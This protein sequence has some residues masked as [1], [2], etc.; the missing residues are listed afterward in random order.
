V[1][2]G[3]RISCER[4]LGC[5][6]CVIVLDTDILDFSNLWMPIHANL[7]EVSRR[8]SLMNITKQSLVKSKINQEVTVG[9]L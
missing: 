1:L 3:D 6:C 2:E 9:T 5:A 4:V 8:V 7:F